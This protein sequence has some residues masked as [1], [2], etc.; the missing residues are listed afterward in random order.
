LH[1]LA[2]PRLHAPAALLAAILPAG[3]VPTDAISAGIDAVFGGDWPAEPLWLCSVALR[4]GRRVAFGRPGSPETCVGRAVAASCAVPGYF[5]PVTIGG[6]RYVDG[7]LRSFTNMDLIVG[8]GLDL[9]IVSAPMSQAPG[10][11]VVSVDTLLRQSLS[12]RLRREVAAL[13]RA[14]V[15][16]VTIEPDREVVRAMGLNP[17]DSRPRGVVSRATRRR[18]GDWLSEHD[19]GRWLVATLGAASAET[20]RRAGAGARVAVAAPPP[21]AAQQIGP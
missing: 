10:W 11:P 19:D 3:G 5:K 14:G 18:V 4:N 8:S 2:H 12:A 20:K 13:R 9:V 16:V 15:P 21:A 7:G 17:M 6:R 1:G